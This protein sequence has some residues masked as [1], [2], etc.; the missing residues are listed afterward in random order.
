M[1]RRL[2]ILAAGLG[3][4]LLGWLTVFG[5]FL[6]APAENLVSTPGLSGLYVRQELPVP[7][8]GQACTSGV[9]LVAPADRVRYLAA[10]RLSSPD[11]LSVTIRGE[12]LRAKGRTAQLAEAGPDTFI[13]LPFSPPAGETTVKAR[14]CIRTLERPLKLVGTDEGNSVV[15]ATTTVDGRPTSA[16]IALNVLGGRELTRWESLRQVP[17]RIAQATG[18]LSGPLIAALAVLVLIALIGIPLGALLSAQGHDRSVQ[19]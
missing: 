4:L 11:G 7:R 2:A 10:G 3:L 5:P 16:D 18:L 19:G 17:D 12:S 14:L 13:T 9:T 8:G 6:R 1:R 15:Q